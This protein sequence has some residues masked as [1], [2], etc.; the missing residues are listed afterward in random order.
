M[1]PAFWGMQIILCTHMN[2]REQFP[3]H[4]ELRWK[5]MNTLPNTQLLFCGDLAWPASWKDVDLI[6]LV[7][8]LG[9]P[10]MKEFSRAQNS[11]KKAPSNLQV[12]IQPNIQH[13]VSFVSNPAGFGAPMHVGQLGPGRYHA[14]RE[15][16]GQ[17]KERVVSFRVRRED[18]TLKNY[19]WLSAAGIFERKIGK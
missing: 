3:V 19:C 18:K 11:F 12:L 10:G 8:T 13:R 7:P 14:R 5:W 4:S 16:I 9:F 17:A 2:W 1:N 6:L 15:Q